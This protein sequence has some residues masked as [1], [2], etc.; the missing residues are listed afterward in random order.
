[1]AKPIPGRKYTIV[2]GD[3]LWDIS[4]AAYGN[5]RKYTVIW[6]ANRSQLRSNDPNLIFPGEVLWIPRD[7]DVDKAVNDMKAEA[8]IVDAV[9]N[10]DKGDATFVVGGQE[11]L[12]QN[13]L[14][15]ARSIING[16]YAY[17]CSMPWQLEDERL[18][19]VLRPYSYAPSELYLGGQKRG[20]GVIYEVG[21]QNTKTGGRTKNVTCYSPTADLVDS[22]AKP[23]YQFE[24]MKFSQIIERV[25][26]PFGISVR[27]KSSKDKKFKRVTI[28][29]GQRIFDFLIG[30]ARQ[31]GVL[32][33]TNEM[34][35]LEIADVATGD[36][37]SFLSEADDLV[38]GWQGRWDGRQRFKSYTA[39]VTTPRRKPVISNSVDQGVPLNRQL[40]FNA[41]ETD[42]TT[43]GDA[44]AWKKAKVLA[45]SMRISLTVHDWYDKNGK[46]WDENTLVRIESPTLYVPNGYTFLLEGVE[47]SRKN[48]GRTSKL[49][50]VPPSLYNGEVEDFP[51]S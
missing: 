17:S 13:D 2:K 49:D 18:A 21:T 29:K 30:L 51:W 28:D 25:V 47:M 20:S 16:C 41:N 9:S 37:V 33:K 38:Q 26:R 31:I 46:M 27:Y 8:G 43:I 6:E 5:P 7:G 15:I 34:G 44:A 42:N 36:P 19:E 11:I 39:V 48:G 14:S 3:T 4:S 12:I 32:L 23:P 24:N 50:F 35:E 45:E 22:T 40:R 10:A 1:M